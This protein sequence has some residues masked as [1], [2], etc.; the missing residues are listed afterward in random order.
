MINAK[1]KTLRNSGSQGMPDV[2]GAV[3][4]FLQPM[5]LGV[6]TK[7]QV[8]GLTEE[9]T[10]WTYSKGTRQPY[11]AQQLKMLPEGQRAWR[12]YTIHCLPDVVLKPDD[13]ITVQGLRMRVMEKLDYLEYGYL[14]YHAVEDLTSG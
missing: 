7:K 11:T 3:E 4:M 8:R 6:I 14:E 1:D 13:I 9:E 10:F 12:W 5:K 2:S